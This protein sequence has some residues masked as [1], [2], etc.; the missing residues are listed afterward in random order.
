[1]IPGTEHYFHL[2]DQQ[3]ERLE[4]GDWRLFDIVWSADDDDPR[5][6]IGEVIPQP[7]SGLG[8]HTPQPMPVLTPAAPVFICI[9]FIHSPRG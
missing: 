5:F 8:G 2:R 6:P 4:R 7:P 1:M 3:E 9:P